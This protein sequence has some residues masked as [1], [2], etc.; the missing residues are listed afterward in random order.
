MMKERILNLSIT[1]SVSRPDSG[2]RSTPNL[3][4]SEIASRL[5]GGQAQG[6]GAA[7]LRPLLVSPSQACKLLGIS[8]SGLYNLLNSGNLE[9]FRVGGSRRITLASI[10][11]FVAERVARGLCPAA[12]GR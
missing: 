9:S 5:L 12:T 8:M 6:S 7:D 10:E 2:T 3:K 4:D 1:G 11:K